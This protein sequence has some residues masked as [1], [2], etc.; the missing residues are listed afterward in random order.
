MAADDLPQNIAAPAANGSASAASILVIDDEAG[1]RDSLEVL[2]TFEGYAV[3]MAADGEQGLRI[4]ELENFDLVL[5][6]LA[7]PG[8]SG[9]E[10]LP[11]IKERQPEVPV[12]MITAYG[13]VDN[14]VESVRAGAENFVQ[15]P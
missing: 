13:T 9:L 14:V 15:K 2:L 5:L 6:D 10:L 1:I 12:I 3:K 7:L 8:R 11:M 4:L